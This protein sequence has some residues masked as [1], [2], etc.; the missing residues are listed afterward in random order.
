MSYAVKIT[1]M[2]ESLVKPAR[3]GRK[4]EEYS[5][6]EYYE[7]DYSSSE[8]LSED[9]Y[10]EIMHN[11]YGSGLPQVFAEEFQADLEEQGLGKEADILINHFDDNDGKW[12]N[13]WENILTKFV[14]DGEYNLHMGNDGLY[15]LRIGKY[16][17]DWD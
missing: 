17:P 15:A 14:Y 1:R 8:E 11:H 3:K 2:M 5:E 10:F 7:D 16:P 4:N 9:D 13:A 12:A 6:E